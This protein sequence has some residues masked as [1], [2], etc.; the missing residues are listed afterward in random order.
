MKS[1]KNNQTPR[2]HMNSAAKYSDDDDD[3]IKMTTV[4]YW[5]TVATRSYEIFIPSLSLC[6]RLRINTLSRYYIWPTDTTLSIFRSSALPMYKIGLKAFHFSFPRRQQ[7]LL[8]RSTQSSRQRCVQQLN[9]VKTEL[10]YE[11][12]RHMIAVFTRLFSGTPILSCQLPVE[13][14]D[15]GLG[16][17]W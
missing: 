12:I 5:K 6:K 8:Q 9:K 10:S 1:W 11:V 7:A 17:L 4:H 15:F 2:R 16:A 14:S 3:D 13:W